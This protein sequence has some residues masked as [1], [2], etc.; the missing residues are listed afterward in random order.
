MMPLL[1]EY[2][3]AR[4]PFYTYILLASQFC[5][6]QQA[7]SSTRANTTPSTPVYEQYYVSTLN[8]YVFVCADVSVMS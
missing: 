3:V 1:T 2:M 5:S 4:I 7:N 6:K 8:V